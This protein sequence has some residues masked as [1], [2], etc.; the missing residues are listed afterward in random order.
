VVRSAAATATACRERPATRARSARP[1]GPAAVVWVARHGASS[2]LLGLSRPACTSSIPASIW[3]RAS[4]PQAA[5]P[6]RPARIGR[7]REPLILGLSTTAA[8][9]LLRQQG[10]RPKG[11]QG[12]PVGGW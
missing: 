12:G 2:R 5:L 4:Q 8:R 6:P 10:C 3:N 11:P 1:A 7:S 9:S